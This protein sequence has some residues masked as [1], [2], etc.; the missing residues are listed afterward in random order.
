[1]SREAEELAKVEHQVLTCAVNIA[2]LKARMGSI[3]RVGK[4]YSPDLHKLKQLES[5]EQQLIERRN[6]LSSDVAGNDY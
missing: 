5:E 6:A 2:K 4:S 3:E 1:M